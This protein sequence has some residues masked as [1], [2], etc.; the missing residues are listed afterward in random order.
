MQ[1]TLKSKVSEI[2][3]KYNFSREDA[4][5]ISDVLN[6]IDNRQDE[7]FQLSKELFLTQKDKT[8]II[9]K[10][11]NGKTDL[12]EKIE[13][14]KTELNGKI[15]NVKIELIERIESIKT[16]FNATLYKTVFTVGII[17]LL[18]II[19]SVLAIINYM[20]K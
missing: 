6:E 19:G 10:V 9:G 3:T 13:S 20:H 8:E 15:D 12:V 18:A 17:Q 4:G 16:E 1:A 11:E 5:F 7:K 14:T 2:F